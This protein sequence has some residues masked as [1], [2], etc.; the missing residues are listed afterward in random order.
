MG[1]PSGARLDDLWRLDDLEGLLGAG[2]DDP[3][4]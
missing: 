2:L 4:V 3:C 1:D